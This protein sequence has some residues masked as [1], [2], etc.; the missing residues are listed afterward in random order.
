L[1]R[2]IGL[3]V[4]TTNIGI[5]VCDEDKIMAFPLCVIK[6]D[7]INRMSIKAIESLSKQL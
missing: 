5:S 4:G 6:R 3:D 1:K 7:Q 2:L